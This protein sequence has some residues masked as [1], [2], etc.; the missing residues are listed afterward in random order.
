MTYPEIPSKRKR[1]ALIF[2]SRLIKEVN[3]ERLLPFSVC[4]THYIFT[5]LVKLLTI[6]I[7]FVHLSLALDAYNFYSS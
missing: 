5:F 1:S 4:K 3:A 7:T 2:T 6:I